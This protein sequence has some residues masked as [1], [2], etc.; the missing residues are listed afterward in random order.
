MFVNVFEDHTAPLLEPLTLTR[1]A[2]ALRC[3]ART[4]LERQAGHFSLDPRGVW[5]SPARVELCTLGYPTLSVNN[6][7]SLV[8]PGSV[9]VNGRWLP[10]PTRPGPL[11][12]AGVGMADDQIAFVVLPAGVPPPDPRRP[13]EEW[14]AEVAGRLPAFEAGGRMIQAPWDLIEANGEALEED[15]DRWRTQGHY[16][17]GTF[18][19]P[20]L[21]VLGS[22]ARVLI[23]PSACIDAAVV[24]DVRKG[25]VLIDR[26]VTV[27]SFTRIEGPCWVGAGTQLFAARIY[28]GS[29]GPQCR[30]GG[31]LECS[32]VHGHTNKRHD[33]F[34]GHSY[35]G[36]WVNFGA[37]TQTSDLRNDYEKVRVKVAGQLRQTGLTKVGA[38]V[39]D[40]TRTSIGALLNTGSSVGP[41]CQLLASGS[42]L[43]RE[44]PAFTE[45]KNG[46]LHERTDSRQLVATASRVLAR[47]GHHWTESHTELFFRLYEETAPHR[48]QCL[49]EKAP[50]R[51]HLVS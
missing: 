17:D 3:G 31:E 45:F 19:R 20:G 40:H 49:L 24:I 35:I 51:W 7:A 46:R 12:A 34:L 15:Y 42:L 47:R 28:G 10:P 8:A 6:P 44:M 22:P 37:G 11:P 36:E 25:P 32:I 13:F 50:R 18:T 29:Y 30:L 21:T 41:F 48:K 14:L 39:G 1:P 43:P 9:L 23:D 38:F 33:G 2:F 4:L 5:I 16:L 27:E 26:E